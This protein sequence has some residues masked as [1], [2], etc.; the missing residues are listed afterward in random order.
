MAPGGSPRQL[1]YRGSQE[2][3]CGQ[4]RSKSGTWMGMVGLTSCSQTPAAP[5]NCSETT[6]LEVSKPAVWWTCRARRWGMRC[7]LR[8]ETW[9]ETVGWTLWWRG[10]RAGAFWSTTTGLALLTA[11]PTSH[12]PGLWEKERLT[13]RSATW[14]MT[15]S[16]TLCWV[17]GATQTSCYATTVPAGSANQRSWLAG[18]R[19]RLPSPSE[20]WTETGVWT[21]WS[22]TTTTL[23][24]FC[25]MMA[26]ATSSLPSC[27]VAKRGRRRWCSATSTAT[28]SWM[29]SLGTPSLMP[30]CSSTT[31]WA[32]SRRHKIWDCREW[33]PWSSQT[34][35]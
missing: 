24:S 7:D 16:L 6:A 30:T 4:K 35:T 23:T 25:A 8:L 15:G 29:S 17:S 33:W 2:A 26:R 3:D 5:T 34:S 18:Q 19:P 10:R 13:W 21:S 11:S 22:A 12:S 32:A 20:T 9:T 27:R 31:W 1:S 28:D 14:T